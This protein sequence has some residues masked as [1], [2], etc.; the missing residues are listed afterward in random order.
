MKARGRQIFCFA[1]LMIALVTLPPSPAQAIT[2]NEAIDVVFEALARGGQVAGVS[3]PE[4]AKEV[5][6]ELVKCGANGTPITDCAKQ[7]VI[8]AL[9][10]GVPDEAKK[11]VGCLLGGGDILGCA[12]AAGLDNLPPQAKPIV[13][14][15]LSGGTVAAC[16]GKAALGEALAK[17]PADV[18]PLLECIASGRSAADCG[19]QALVNGLPDGEAKDVVNCLLKGNTPEDCA[20]QFGTGVVDEATKKQTA[21]VIKHLKDLKADAEQ[22]LEDAKGTVKSIIEIAKGIQ[23]AD[24]GA[25][26]YYGGKEFAKVVLTV[27]VDIFCPPCVPISGQVVGALVDHYAGLAEDTFKA[28]LKGDAGAMPEIIFAFY[29]NETIVRPC[30]LL[31]EGAFKDSVC[32]NLKKAIDA[33]AGVFGDAVDIVLGVAKD[34]LKA[35]GAW[36]IVE[37]V[38][39]AIAGVVS[40]I[41]DAI[42]GNDNGLKDPKVCGLADA[43]FANNYLPC[44]GATAGAGALTPVPALH[45]AC[46]ANF[47]R[48]YANPEEICNG[49]DKAL[50]DTAEKVN[51][52][53]EQGAG[54]LTPALGAFIYAR[55]EAIC[56]DGKANRYDNFP[57]QE[58]IGQCRDALNKRV[59]LQVNACMF[60]A[61]GMKRPPGPSLACTQ[62]L[63]NANWKQNVDK[64]CDDW[65]RDQ[66]YGCEPRPP[67]PEWKRQVVGYD[68][69]YTLIVP[70]EGPCGSRK[71]LD[72]WKDVWS[73]INPPNVIYDKRDVVDILNNN[74]LEDSILQKSAW[75]DTVTL[76]SRGS[77]GFNTVKPGGTSIRRQPQ[78][79]SG[80]YTSR[81]SPAMDRLTGGGIGGAGS[82]AP[83][84]RLPDTSRGTIRPGG[85]SV[86]RQ[87]QSS[88]GFN[89]VQPGGTAVPRQPQG[90]SGS[91]PAVDYGGSAAPRSP[92]P[93]R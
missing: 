66:P 1:L 90:S 68:I 91:S 32:G 12:K 79:S 15:M 81:S 87:P 24:W 64:V 37:G 58:F 39:G 21:E 80:A 11:I 41:W 76:P 33:A 16:A 61:G 3:I 84:L 51:I 2:Q 82:S 13:E 55:R 18:R 36:G 69:Q 25:V 46:V 38:A 4:D 53:L 35:V 40:E 63:R 48:C 52:A 30:A 59:S 22:A 10:K 70:E 57:F 43:F 67:C 60:K 65:C 44:L 85:I 77:S 92:S 29:L 9:L 42:T 31:P 74:R 23:N 14:C 17:V 86:P 89:T 62:A 88:S 45:A 49:L 75:S 50:N 34:V 5:L 83:G 7:A 73:V 28:A 27:V 8:N 78:S 26:V 19:A 54:A 20:A 6:K 93:V 71:Y 72:N 47:K 56:T